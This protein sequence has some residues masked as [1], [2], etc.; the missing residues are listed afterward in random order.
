ME[1]TSSLEE[2]ATYVEECCTFRGSLAKLE[3]NSGAVLWQTLMLPDNHGKKG[4]Y[5]GAAIVHQ[6]VSIENMCILLPETCTLSLKM[7]LNTKKTRIIIQ[8]NPD[9]CVEPAKHVNS[10]LALDLDS[11]NIK[12]YHQ[13]GGYDV[14]GL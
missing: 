14:Y 6:S 8:P 4:Q 12:W 9:A 1:R 7:Q 10:I 2:S 11:G 3:V 13:L 5:S